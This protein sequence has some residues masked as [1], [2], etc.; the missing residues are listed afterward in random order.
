MWDDVGPA[1]GELLNVETTH[2]GTDA[3]LRLTGELDMSSAEW[4]GACVGTVLAS[5]PRSIRIDAQGLTF[6][7]SSGLRSLL[8]ARRA[9][10]QAGVAF[11]VSDPSRPLRNMVERTGVQDLFLEE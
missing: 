11:H 2:E 9:A 1:F 10:D 3:V 7:D 5:D 4:F 6:L 8:L